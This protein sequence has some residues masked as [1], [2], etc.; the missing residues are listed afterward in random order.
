M[1]WLFNRKLTG[2]DAA[3]SMQLIRHLQT[4]MALQHLAMETYNTGLFMAA[5]NV[6]PGDDVS[7]RGMATIVDP[8]FAEKQIVPAAEKKVDIAEAMLEEHQ[9][10]QAVQKPEKSQEAYN[11]WADFAIIHLARARLQ[12]ETWKEWVASP[13]L[14]VAGLEVRRSSLDQ[15]EHNSMTAALDAL[16]RLGRSLGFLERVPASFTAFNEVWSRLGLSQLT[17][18]DFEARINGALAGESIRFFD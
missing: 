14:N 9:G 3:E 18:P 5:S 10:F 4:Q 6:N 1:R 8:S 17:A 16:N 2:K 13:S 7:V 12:L 15:A 11:K